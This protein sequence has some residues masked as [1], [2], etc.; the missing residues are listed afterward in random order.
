MLQFNFARDFKEN[1]NYNKRVRIN[2]VDANEPYVP[3][4]SDNVVRPNDPRTVDFV[5]RL[6]ILYY[7]SDRLT[8]NQVSEMIDPYYDRMVDAI[9]N[10]YD[11]YDYSKLF[12]D[13]KFIMALTRKLASEHSNNREDPYVIWNIN[14]LLYRSMSSIDFDNLGILDAYKKLGYEANRL[15]IKKIMDINTRGYN[16]EPI[17]KDNALMIAIARY[18]EV[19]GDVVYSI[20]RLNN[21]IKSIADCTK[22]FNEDVLIDLYR[23]LIDS[24]SALVSGTFLRIEFDFNKNE[25]SAKMEQ[26]QI[27][28]VLTLLDNQTFEVIEYSLREFTNRY[29]YRSSE[30]ANFDKVSIMANTSPDNFPNIWKVVN[31][32]S[33][34]GYVVH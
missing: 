1:K 17:N 8:Q 30:I 6:G 14:T 31:K 26:R 25:E 4:S 21:T 10:K 29:N 5:N 15:L 20:A 23:V 7:H 24:M 33:A 27:S 18:S 11:G 13:E 16:T 12:K 2:I 3:D 34:E 22:I 9:A 28:T 32:L 19:K